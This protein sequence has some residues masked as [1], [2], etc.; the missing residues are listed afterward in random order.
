MGLISLLG[1]GPVTTGI[2][3]EGIKLAIMFI[4]NLSLL[5][6]KTPDE[7][8]AIFDESYEGLKK[9]DPGDLPDV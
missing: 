3:T 6:G 4:S 8:K 9:R 1:A 7:I 5:S 2:I